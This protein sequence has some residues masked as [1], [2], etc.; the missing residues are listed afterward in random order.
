M[1]SVHNLG[2][3]LLKGVGLCSTI[4][5]QL[6]IYFREGGGIKKS[7]I[8]FNMGGGEGVREGVERECLNEKSFENNN[9]TDKLLLG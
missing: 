6:I 5:N 7:E 2:Y 3:L 8:F 1:R 9:K 4:L